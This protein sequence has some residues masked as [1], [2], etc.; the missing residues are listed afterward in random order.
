LT[1]LG[2]TG[3]PVICSF[4]IDRGCLIEVKALS[5]KTTKLLSKQ[6]NVW[7]FS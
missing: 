5:S 3:L 6:P 2:N 4:A 1:A 7:L